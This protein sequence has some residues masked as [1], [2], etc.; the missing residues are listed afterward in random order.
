MV[1]GLD[2][3]AVTTTRLATL[4]VKKRRR[5]LPGFDKM[6]QRNNIDQTVNLPQRHDELASSR[7][8]NGP[9]CASATLP[10]R[11]GNGRYLRKAD[12]LEM[13]QLAAGVIRNMDGQGYHHRRALL[14]QPAMKEIGKATARRWGS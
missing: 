5:A 9:Y 13:D 4:I 14:Y 10:C 3:F 2:D 11:L 8:T 1:I 7:S 6:L 12:C